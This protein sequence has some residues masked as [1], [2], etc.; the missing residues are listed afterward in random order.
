[1]PKRMI[2][3][4][5]KGGVGRTTIATALATALAGQG[6]KVLLAHVRT[7]QRVGELLGCEELDEWIREVEPNLWAVNM[8]PRAALREQGLKVLRF[9]AVYKAVM[10]NRLVR[11]F[12]RAIPSLDEYS[13]LGKAWY[14]TTEVDGEGANRFDTVIFDGPATGH[15]ITMLRIPQVILDVVPEGPLTTDA[16]QVRDLLCDPARSM[17]M[18]VTLAEEMAVSEAKDLFNAA[19]GDLRVDTRLL[20]VN[21]VYPDD[22]ERREGLDAAFA[23]LLERGVSGALQPFV[24][25]AATLRSRRAINKVHLERLEQ[26]I[27]VPRLE[28]PHLFTPSLAR[29]ELDRLAALL[30]PAAAAAGA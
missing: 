23:G 26:E 12:L 11:Y 6:R 7:R 27:P 14:H 29:E 22:L 13:M 8:N 3:V 19:Q 16:R 20:V 18:I 1:M 5:G 9:K 10:E 4:G 2:I 15:L 25:A 17:M 28:L 30:A 24:A 21:A